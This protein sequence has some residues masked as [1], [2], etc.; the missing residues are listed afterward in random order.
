MSYLENHKDML[1]TIIQIISDALNLDCAV[2]DTESNLIASTTQYL[3]R[4]G[5]SV[6][7]PSFEEVILNGN[8][9]VN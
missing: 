7:A 1:K 9:L 6:H 4:K 3:K 8:I 2:F 5:S